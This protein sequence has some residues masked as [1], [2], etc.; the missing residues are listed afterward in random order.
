MTKEL[1]KIIIEMR[2]E[3]GVPDF[4]Y[5]DI[6]VCSD[7]FLTSNNLPIKGKFI[8]YSPE[9]TNIALVQ[10]F[11]LYEGIHYLDL[12]HK[13]WLQHLE[14]LPRVT[15]DKTLY[16]MWVETSHLSLD[17]EEELPSDTRD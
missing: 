3:L 10:C 16:Y 12:P 6:V 5:K 14:E 8:G 15:I 17:Y 9:I 2:R 11:K 1:A 13:H 7:I 4:A